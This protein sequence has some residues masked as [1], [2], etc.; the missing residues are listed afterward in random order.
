ML[1]VAQGLIVLAGPLGAQVL[2]GRPVGAALAADAEVEPLTAREREVLDLL[3]QGLANKQIARRLA[4]SEHTVKFHVSALYANL[5][6]SGRTD[7]ISRGARRGLIT[8]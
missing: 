6:A 1:A 5:G 7:A 4:I 2:G 3:G 8:L